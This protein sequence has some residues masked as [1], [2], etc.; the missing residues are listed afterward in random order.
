MF[1][2]PNFKIIQKL[3]T[4]I[5][6]FLILILLNLN[7]NSKPTQ[8]LLINLYGSNDQAIIKENMVTKK[9]SLCNCRTIELRNIGESLCSDAADSRGPGQKVFSFALYSKQDKPLEQRFF[10]GIIRNIQGVRK[11]FPGYNMRLY[12]SVDKAHLEG[13]CKLFCEND[14]LDICDTHH[15]GKVSN[16]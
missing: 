14:E 4:V 6:V 9:D 16:I 5:L 15:T 8:D 1:S 13:L 10:R 11:L 2:S 7:L 12:Y 3:L